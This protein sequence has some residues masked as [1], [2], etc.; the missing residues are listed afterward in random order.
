[1]QSYLVA[2]EELGV[3]P[4]L[5][6]LGARGS[7]RECRNKGTQKPLQPAQEEAEVVAGGGEHG[8]D[9]V[10][11]ASLEIIAVHAV[12]GLE[13]VDHWL[14]RGA[15]LLLSMMPPVV[16]VLGLLYCSNLRPCDTSLRTHHDL[17]DNKQLSAVLEQRT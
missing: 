6:E 4:F 13:V 1:M 16:A 15:P 2:R 8:V 12:L 10:A 3:A 7:W 9:A 5:A 14:D 17:V 11:V